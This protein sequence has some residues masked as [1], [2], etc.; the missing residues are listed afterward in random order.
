MHI[1]LFCPPPKSNVTTASQKS[2]LCCPS[3]KYPLFAV[4]SV[5]VAVLLAFSSESFATSDYYIVHELGING[6]YQATPDREEYEFNNQGNIPKAAGRAEALGTTT[7]GTPGDAIVNGFKYTVQ[8]STTSDVISAADA[9]TAQGSAQAEGNTLILNN[10]EISAGYVH[11]AY[12]RRD[13]KSMNLPNSDGTFTG[14]NNHL[15]IENSPIDSYRISGTYIEI[16]GNEFKTVAASGNSV[17]IKNSSLEDAERNGGQVVAAD[18]YLD[19]S[20]ER[21]GGDMSVETLTANNNKVHIEGMGSDNGVLRRIAAVRNDGINAFNTYVDSFQ[22]NSNE[23]DISEL[24]VEGA[25]TV[26]FTGQEHLWQGGGEEGPES[27]FYWRNQLHLKDA[28]ITNNKLRISDSIVVNNAGAV[29]VEKNDDLSYDKIRDNEVHLENVTVNGAVFGAAYVEIQDTWIEE[30]EYFGINE[31]NS[32]YASG[33]NKVGTID[34]FENLTL[35]VSENNK[36]T[37]NSE[38]SKAVIAITGANETI[39]FTGRNMIVEVASGFTLANKDI[40]NLI[41]VSG[42]DSKLVLPPGFTITEGNTFTATSYEIVGGQMT[43]NKG[44]TLAI[45]VDGVVDPTGPDDSDGNDSHWKVTTQTTDNAKTLAESF[46][47]SAAIVGLGTEYIAD[48]GLSMMVDSAKLSGRNAFGAIYGGTG[49][50]RTGSRL[51]LDSATLITGISAMTENQK[52]V[53]STFVE[54]GWGDSEGHVN[55]ANAK[56]DHNVYSLGTAMRF[57]TD[58]P[59]YFDASARLGVARFD[60]S[61]NFATES[62]KFDHSGIYA[63]LHGAVGYAYPITEDTI[64]DSY[65]R[66]SFTYLE[67]GTEELHNNAQNTFEMDSIRASAFRLGARL[68]GYFGEEKDLNY[69]FGVAYEKVVHGDA[70]T[71]IDGMSIDAPSLNGDSAVVE[72]GL[73]KRPT[74]QSPWGVDVTLK[75]YAGDREGLYGSATLNYVF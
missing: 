53:A 69:R 22:A 2:T 67:G 37:G 20:L 68:K 29:L 17:D 45:T 3:S 59:L 15:I 36:S 4:S 71:Q 57:F 19:R 10:V 12:V 33:R 66:Y 35:T 38:A 65:L 51:D 28:E 62:V 1:W 47:G 63:A 31:G 27:E 58:S 49:K 25:Y 44:D 55:Q 61:G 54:V 48:E 8:N 72:V 21:D 14:N 30:H 74:I 16:Y 11:A 50:Y 43:F 73:A 6:T 46:L 26:W 75:G 42:E 32:I 9:I 5:L 64:L 60:Y 13:P 70:D 41:T 23:V 34:G 56:A 7:N 18:I 40:L 52:L 39:D 24:S